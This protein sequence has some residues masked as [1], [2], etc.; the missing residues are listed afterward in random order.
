MGGNRHAQE[1]ATVRGASLGAAP[2]F[3]LRTLSKQRVFACAVGALLC[4]F[5]ISLNLA[6][7]PEDSGEGGYVGIVK[8]FCNA[9][10]TLD[11]TYLLAL[12]VIAIFFLFLFGFKREPMRTH[13]P[14]V[15]LS[16]FAGFAMT[17]GWT[18][19]QG[20]DI[21]VL[22]RDGVQKAKAVFMLAG[23]AS[24]AYA[25][26]TLSFRILDRSVEGGSTPWRH[27][28]ESES[29]W[30]SVLH[31]LA[32]AFDRHP[33]AIPVVVLAIAWMPMLIGYQPGLFM[34]DTP[35]Q[36]NMWF[37]YPHDRLGGITLVD[38]NITMTTHHPVLH[39][40][41]VGICVQCGQQ[42]LGDENA[43][44]ALYT[45]L[46]WVI[47]ILCVAY[48]FQVAKRLG[49]PAHWRA[50][51]L[52]LFMFVP[53]YST[54]AV[55]VTKDSLFAD[56]LLVFTLQ[57]LLLWDECRVGGAEGITPKRIAAL[58]VSGIL[59]SL[60]RNGA[61]LYVAGGLIVALLVC[62]ARETHARRQCLGSFA[63]TLAVVLV[64]NMALVPALHI[65]PSSKVEVLSVPFQHTARYV[66]EHP[67]DVEPWEQCA[68]DAILDYEGLS[69][70]YYANNSDPV[71]DYASEVCGQATAD[72]WAE[73]FKAWISMGM[74]HPGC[75]LEATMANYYGYFYIGQ[76][77]NMLYDL[78]NSNYRMSI[79]NEG[80]HFDFHR[81]DGYAVW[82]LGDIDSAYSYL[83]KR[84]PIVSLPLNAAFWCWLLLLTTAYAIRRRWKFAAPVLLAL[85]LV[86]LVFLIGPT[87]GNIYNRYAYPL[88]FVL[89]FM[90]VVL[91]AMAGRSTMK[92]RPQPG[93]AQHAR[94]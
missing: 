46:Q 21:G 42:L 35:T 56:A 86:M 58:V 16:V 10:P 12:C 93:A 33:F 60:L 18:L 26:F 3:R 89:P 39:T 73:Y 45:G 31:R 67:Q 9:W 47:C 43:G 81:T 57:L 19:D 15:V 50:A 54:F 85:W 70:R 77:T 4:C 83:F 53:W 63:A 6:Y 92:A 44:I 52:L 71:K 2:T 76:H 65:A 29:R 7:I 59:T 13:W 34:G 11:A 32:K 69:E 49:V 22:L 87:N 74:R 84:M 17:F 30:D 25:G 8:Q 66:V 28:I 79:I 5:A 37:G 20:Y 14:V 82:L 94:P 61:L 68:I 78:G 38:P 51:A 36:I 64:F 75:Y 41:L 24:I 1:A 48:A 80:G 62:T 40:A 91:P 27:F 55:V 90:L 23:W 72:E 88:A